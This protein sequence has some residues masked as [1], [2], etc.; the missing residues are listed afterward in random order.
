MSELLSCPFCGWP[1]PS[2]R[3]EPYAHDWIEYAVHCGNCDAESAMAKTREEAAGLWNRRT[4]RYSHRNGE[5]EPP[6][7]AGWYWFKG[8]V[9]VGNHLGFSVHFDVVRL[10]D[11][12]LVAFPNDY[13]ATLRNVTGRW[14]GPIVPPFEAT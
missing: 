11:S 5:T 9:S 7:K 8:S 14:W 3:V 4:P 12:Q 6:T 10:D 2:W 13:M 1:N